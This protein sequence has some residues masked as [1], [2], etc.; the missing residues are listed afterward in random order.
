[1]TTATLQVVDGRDGTALGYLVPQVGMQTQ[2]GQII[3]VTAKGYT[4]RNM[5]NGSEYRYVRGT[6]GLVA[7]IV[8]SEAKKWGWSR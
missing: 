1:M 7:C 4:T 5:K 3:R 2:R 8:Q 6:I